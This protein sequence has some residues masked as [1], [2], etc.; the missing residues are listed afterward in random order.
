MLKILYARDDEKLTSKLH[1]H[2]A[3]CLNFGSMCDL[4][5]FVMMTTQGLWPFNDN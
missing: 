1:Q 4:V 2:Q 3:I 5:T